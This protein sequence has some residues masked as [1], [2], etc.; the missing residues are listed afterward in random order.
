MADPVGT[1][2][3]AEVD[4]IEEWADIQ[5][6]KAAEL[7]EDWWPHATLERTRWESL[8]EYLLDKTRLLPDTPESFADDEETWLRLE[9]RR[10]QKVKAVVQTWRRQG[11]L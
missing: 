2:E 4:L 5:D 1:G 7:Q 8:A 9:E 10:R 3:P 11:V 6:A